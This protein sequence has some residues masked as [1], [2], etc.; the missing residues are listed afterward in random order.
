VPKPLQA[1]HLN[2]KE[3]FLHHK[4]LDL[5]CGVTITKGAKICI[6]FVVYGAHSQ[7][8]KMLQVLVRDLEGV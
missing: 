1:S 7:V 4:E 3:K 2:H 6:R 5:C 8:I